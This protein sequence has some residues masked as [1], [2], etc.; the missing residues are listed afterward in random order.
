MK[1]ELLKTTVFL[2]ALMLV[3]GGNALAQRGY[4][5]GRGCYRCMD[6]PGLPEKQKTEIAK[7][8]QEHRKEMDEM[9]TEWRQ[10]EAFA[11][12]EKHLAEV[13]KK[14]ETH[15]NEIKNLLTE[16]QK[17]VFDYL[18]SGNGR[19]RAAMAGGGMGRLGGGRAGWCRGGRYG[20]GW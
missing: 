19:N 13:D 11:Q 10:S 18:G 17:A 20:R 5:A 15:R 1:R 2:F 8:V 7:L 9:R 3:A 16:E 14:V 4:G 12:H 6:L